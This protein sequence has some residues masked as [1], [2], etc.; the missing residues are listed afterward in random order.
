MRVAALEA[1]VVGDGVD[2]EGEEMAVG[3]EEEEEEVFVTVADGNVRVGD[4]DA[5][6]QNCWASFSSVVSSLGQVDSTQVNTSP[7][8]SGLTQ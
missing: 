4:K 8:K 5:R 2:C 3:F 1:E 6:L 7:G